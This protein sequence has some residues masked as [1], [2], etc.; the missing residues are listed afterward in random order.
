[1]RLLYILPHGDIF[2]MIRTD[3]AHVYLVLYIRT[4]APQYEAVIAEADRSFNRGLKARPPQARLMKCR[5]QRRALRCKKQR[6][7]KNDKH[8]R[9]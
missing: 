7:I 9:P 4:K 5:K 3:C 8:L 2:K 6:R 1:M